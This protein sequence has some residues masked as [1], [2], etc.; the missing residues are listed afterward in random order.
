MSLIFLI[1]FASKQVVEILISIEKI[2]SMEI[3]SMH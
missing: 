2:T 3:E 1:N